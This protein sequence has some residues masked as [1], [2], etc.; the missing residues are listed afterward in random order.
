VVAATLRYVAELHWAARGP[1][2]RDGRGSAATEGRGK[3]LFRKRIRRRLSLKE[4]LMQE[5]LFLGN[6]LHKDTVVLY[7]VT[8]HG[9]LAVRETLSTK[10]KKQIR[11]Y[12]TRL[13]ARYRVVAAVEDAAAGGKGEVLK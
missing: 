1:A 11:E 3:G 9:E 7:G 2:I 4:P 13:S 5:T 12:F 8:E 10:C 6:D